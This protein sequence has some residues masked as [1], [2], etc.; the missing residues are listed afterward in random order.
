MDDR[1]SSEI[2]DSYDKIKTKVNVCIN[3]HK[4]QIEVLGKDNKNYCFSPT[5]MKIHY[6]QKYSNVVKHH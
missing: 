3:G 5:V 6:L 4:Q 1:N 2:V